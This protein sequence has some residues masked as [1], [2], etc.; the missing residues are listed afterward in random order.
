MP[1]GTFVPT[2]TAREYAYIYVICIDVVVAVGSEEAVVGI[3]VL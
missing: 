1:E 2:L 3:D